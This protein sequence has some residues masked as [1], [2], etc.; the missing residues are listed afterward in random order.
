[1]AIHRQKIDKG[2]KKCFLPEV[3]RLDP[4]A[5]GLGARLLLEWGA[6]DDAEDEE[7]EEEEEAAGEEVRA[8]DRWEQ[9]H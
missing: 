4:S 2:R 7:E 9:S 8:A 3:L 5:E 6:G 1:M